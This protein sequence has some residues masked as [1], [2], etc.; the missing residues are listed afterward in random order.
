VQRFLLTSEEHAIS[1]AHP[2]SGFA[3]KGTVNLPPLVAGKRDFT[4][5]KQAEKVKGIQVLVVIHCLTQCI[6]ENDP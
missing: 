3:L 2:L 1:H 5:S 4:G 6:V